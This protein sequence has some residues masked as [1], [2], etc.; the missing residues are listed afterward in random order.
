LG[1]GGNDENHV[2]RKCVVVTEVGGDD[3]DDVAVD[4]DDEKKSASL[5]KASTDEVK[6]IEK[7]PETDAVV[8]MNDSD[9]TGNASKLKGLANDMKHTAKRS[10]PSTGFGDNDDTGSA[11]KSKEPADDM[12]RVMKKIKPSTEFDNNIELDD[13]NDKNELKDSDD[14]NGAS[15]AP[16]DVLISPTNEEDKK[17]ASI[18]EMIPHESVKNNEIGTTKRIENEIS[19]VMPV[20]D[21][22]FASAKDEKVMA[23]TE[24]LTKLAKPNDW[25]YASKEESIDDSLGDHSNH[26]MEKEDLN[27]KNKSLESDEKKKSNSHYTI[28]CDDGKSFR[29]AVAING[30]KAYVGKFDFLHQASYASDL[31]RGYILTCGL[32]LRLSDRFGKSSWNLVTRERATKFWETRPHLQGNILLE[33]DRLNEVR[34]IIRYEVLENVDRLVMKIVEEYD[35]GKCNTSMNIEDLF[36]TIPGL[37]LDENNN[38]SGHVK[39]LDNQKKKT[40]PTLSISPRPKS[41]STD[42]NTKNEDGNQSIRSDSVTDLA[43]TGG[44][45]LDEKKLSM[46]TDLAKNYSRLCKKDNLNDP[47]KYPSDMSLPSNSLNQFESLPNVTRFADQNQQGQLRN[48]F[49]FHDLNGGFVREEI[50]VNP[51]LAATFDASKFIRIEKSCI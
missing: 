29:S 36:F 3:N 31:F 7:G 49:R 44:N 11:S 22:C 15:L 18:D 21:N 41:V 20:H 14:N 32:D 16:Q 25:Q 19:T 48:E 1:D 26:T 2:D 35:D 38:V 23:N 8:E 4:D 47:K 33:K 13:S 5:L 30:K 17:K 34:S 37:L 6:G 10:K 40:R 50:L 45:I 42:Q 43:L 9:G 51:T 24:Q 27:S 39:S 12:K 28:P 46:Q